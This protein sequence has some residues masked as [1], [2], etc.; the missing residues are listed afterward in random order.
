MNTAEHRKAI[1]KLDAEIVRLLNAR[2]THVLEIGASKS[3][4]GQELYTPDRIKRLT[5]RLRRLNEGP[6]SDE[7]LRAIYR[8]VIS[9]S[10][11]LHGSMTVAYLGPEATYTHQA[12]LGR[13]GASLNYAPQKTIADVFAEVTRKNAD[14]GVVPIENSTEGVITHTLDLFVDSELKIVAQALMPIN[15]CL[16]G[17]TKQSGIK[18]L[19]S[20]PQALA[21]CRAWIQAHLPQ[22]EVVETSSTTRAAEFAGKERGAAAIASSLAADLYKLKIIQSGIQDNVGNATR[23]LILGRNSP[24]PTGADRTSLMF[25]IAHKTGALHKA[26]E[27]F[28]RRRI[29]MT[30]I[31]SRPSKRKAWE[32][33]FFVDI[34]GHE[35]DTKVANALKS[36][37]DH[38]SLVKVLGSYPTMD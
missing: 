30:K 2:T 9:A 13:F 14:Y 32:Y 28:R 21:Q 7:S 24:D 5:D 10:L 4:T 27:P 38:C 20:H 11:S 18:R 31:E 37:S 22:V 29:N 1:D 17:K 16:I 23:F 35:K 8:E 36:L 12:A 33:F 34:D 6:I 19:Y 3:K 15:H 26:L 25:S